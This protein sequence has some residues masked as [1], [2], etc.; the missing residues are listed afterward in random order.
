MHEPTRP[1]TP[2]S[3]FQGPAVSTTV[4]NHRYLSYYILV[5]DPCFILLFLVSSP[6]AHIPI[7][8]FIILI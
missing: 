3:A 8:V 6:F 2:S 4:D 7:N 1:T 5:I